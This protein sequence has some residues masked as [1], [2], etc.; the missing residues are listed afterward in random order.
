MALAWQ[1]V[2]KW[3]PEPYKL[4]DINSANNLKK[5][6]SRFSLR[7]SRMEITPANT[8]ILALWELCQVSELQNRK[9]IYLCCL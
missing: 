7:A 1:A 9:L 5:Q 2:K 6:V 8:L 3:D 4:E